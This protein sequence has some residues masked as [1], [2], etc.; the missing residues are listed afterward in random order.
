VNASDGPIPQLLGDKLY[1]AV[2]DITLTG[3]VS[4]MAG[5]LVS[6]EAFA[7]LDPDLQ[8]IMTEEIRSA[9]EEYTKLQAKKIED[10]R[11][12]LEKLGVKFHD[13]DQDAFREV[14]RSFYAGKINA[15]WSEDLRKKIRDIV[16]S[17]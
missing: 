7:K 1:E 4:M 9:G 14:S 2:H 6:A 16:T 5:I 13:A 17:G 3:H 10:D 11:V 8:K 12:A 15:A